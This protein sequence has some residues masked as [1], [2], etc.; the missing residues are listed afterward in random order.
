VQRLPNEAITGV[1][2]IETLLGILYYISHLE[3][4]FFLGFD[5]IVLGLDSGSVGAMSNM[6]GAEAESTDP[7]GYAPHHWP[8]RTRLYLQLL[9]RLARQ[10]C[11]GGSVQGTPSLASVADAF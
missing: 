3:V 6:S 11:T 4:F 7:L 1:G 10:V 5:E 8:S 9:M 2:L